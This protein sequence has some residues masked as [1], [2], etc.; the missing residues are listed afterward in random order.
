MTHK[1]APPT[2]AVPAA[3]EAYVV[4]SATVEDATGIAEAH[5]ASWRSTYRGLLPQALLDG[6]SVDR[7]GAGWREAIQSGNW[8]VNVVTDPVG[9]IG[10]FIATGGSRDSDATDIVGELLTVY[11]RPELWNLGLGGRLHAVGI[12]RLASRFEEATLW[13]LDTN[14]RS[15][16][17]YE[18]HGWHPDGTVK[19]DTLGGVEVVEV[20]YRRSLHD[21]TQDS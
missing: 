2:G 13:V 8:E 1:Q 9:Q 15:R 7:R 14:A 5:V 3:P 4:R 12:A 16:A 10:G 6:L 17:F 18:R 11:L 21:H 19:H 20:R